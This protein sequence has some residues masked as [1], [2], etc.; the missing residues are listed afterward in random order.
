[1]NNINNIV[2]I[3]KPDELKDLIIDSGRMGITTLILGKIGVGKSQIV[4]E[5]HEEVVGGYFEDIRIST[6]D[7]TDIKGLFEIKDGKT[8]WRIPER[9]YKFCEPGATGVLFF[10]EINLADEGVQSSLYQIILDR[11]IENEKISDGV[12]IVAAGNT[13]D[14]VNMVNNISPALINRMNVVYYE[15][16]VNSIIEY[17]SSKY[18]SQLC[19]N[20]LTYFSI[21]KDKVIEPVKEDYEYYAF[22][23]PRGIEKVMKY[24]S[25]YDYKSLEDKK[26]KKRIY[27]F[28]S[29]AIGVSNANNLMEYINDVNSLKIEEYLNGKRD[30]KNISEKEKYS[31]L[32]ATINYVVEKVNGG[33]KEVVKMLDNIYDKILSGMTK[34][35]LIIFIKWFINRCEAHKGDILKSRMSD[36]YVNIM[37]EIK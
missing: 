3:E 19:N 36:A 26:T 21:F 20:I 7:R 34:D 6:M 16:T 15:P 32:S 22:T 37:K 13:S 8:V 9:I 27:N 23:R 25:K 12:I 29:S 30:I 31:L 33:E 18:N 17:L 11:K 1:M 2:F 35:Y 10:D 28:I 24:I 14:E 4:K 5:L